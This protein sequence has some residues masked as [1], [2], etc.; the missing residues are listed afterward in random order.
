MHLRA[1]RIHLIE[2]RRHRERIKYATLSHCWG[3]K[4]EKHLTRASYNDLKNGTDLA[5]LPRTFREAVLACQILNIEYLWIDSLCIVQDDEDDW[6]HHTGL[7]ANVYASGYVNLAATYSPSSNGGLLGQDQNP[8]LFNPPLLST[9]WSGHIDRKGQFLFYRRAMWTDHVEDAPLNLR[10]WVFQENLLSPRTVHFSSDQIRWRCKQ[11]QGSETMPNIDTR[12]TS[13]SFPL[14]DFAAGRWMCLVDSY[15]KLKLTYSRDI[16][17]A[18]AGIAVAFGKRHGFEPS[19]YIAG[20]WLPMLPQQFLWGCQNGQHRQE[21]KLIPSWTWASTEGEELSSNC[22]YFTPVSEATRSQV[23]VNPGFAVLDICYNTSGNNHFIDGSEAHLRIKGFLHRISLQRPEP[24]SWSSETEPYYE[25]SRL[26]IGTE[27]QLVSTHCLLQSNS[28]PNT[29]TS[30]TLA[31]TA[32]APQTRWKYFSCALDRKWDNLE[33]VNSAVFLPLL[34]ALRSE[35]HLNSDAEETVHGLLLT[36][37]AEQGTYRRIGTM[38]LGRGDRRPGD[39]NEDDLSDLPE[40]HR[41][42]ELGSEEF[43]ANRGNGCYE[44]KL[45]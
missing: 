28:K 42:A 13:L 45:V 12:E 36:R 14:Q 9:Q 33:P 31:E 11:A 21:K 18:F 24:A 27:R 40:W 10:G 32:G 1:A 16:L 25:L 17:A 4:S 3:Q 37:T 35:S 44:I 5:V 26:T 6:R 30:R 39:S 7:M 8:L 29:D 2:A 22:S 38:E 34:Q 15:K 23:L 19:G 20:L 43:L 41:G